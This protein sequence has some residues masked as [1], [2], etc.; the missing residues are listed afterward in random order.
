MKTEPYE[1]QRRSTFAAFR[2]LTR[3]VLPPA[4]TFIV[5]VITLEFAAK[6][7]GIRQF[8]L[9]PPSMVLHALVKDR[10]ELGGAFLQTGLSAACGFGLRSEERR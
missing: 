8:L 2:S 9:P 1:I 3:S 7:F 10:V 6:I 5:V 4:L